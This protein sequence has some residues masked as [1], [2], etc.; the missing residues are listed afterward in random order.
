MQRISILILALCFGLLQSAWA[1]ETFLIGL[2]LKQDSL[3]LEGASVVLTSKADQSKQGSITSSR[4]R[5]RFKG[6]KPGAYTLSVDFVGYGQFSKD[7]ELTEGPN[8]AGRI[9]LGEKSYEL[10]KVVIKG[11]V[12]PSQQKG[13]TTEYNSDAFKTN[14]DATTENLL[15][16]MPGIT[17]QNGQVQAQGEQVRQVLVDGKPF[18]GT[19]PNAALKNLPAEVVQKIQVFDQQSEQA[20]STGFDDGE[21]TKTINIITKPETRNGTFGRLYGGGGLED[22]DKFRYNS[23]G[24]INVFDKN[25]RISILGQVNNIN[26]QNFASEDLAGV[27]SSGG[28]RRGFRGGGGGPPGRRGGSNVSDFLVNEQ[29]GITS[30]N[31]FGIN[32]TD[33]WGKKIEIAGS[34]FFNQ[35]DNVNE[36]VL[37][38][39]YINNGETGQIYEENDTSDSRN[40]NHRLNLR[41][42]F[43]LSDKTRIIFRPRVTVQ[44]NSGAS[45]SNAITSLS[46]Q[47]LNQSNTDFESDLT[48]VSSS[49]FLVF[50]HNFDKRGRSFSAS[51]RANYDDQ[52]GDNLLLSDLEYFSEPAT[53]ELVQQ[54]GTLD[55][56]GWNIR[57]DLRYS[58]PIGK[59]GMLQLFYRVNP[60]IEASDKQTLVPNNS[61]NDFTLIDT[62]LTNTFNS[63]YMTHEPGVG[64]FI[65]KSKLFVISR[66]G[67]QFANLQTERT[68]PSVQNTERDFS[69]LVPFALFRYRFSK[70][71]HLRVIYI[72]R[73]TAP[74]VT[75]LQDVIDN[76]NPLQL[77]SGNP[78]L[79]QSYAHR[80]IIRYNKT[81]TQ[82]NRTFIAFLNA[83]A[84][85]NH[86]G[87]QTIRPRA[88]TTIAGDFPL[89]AGSQYSLPVNLDGY[90]IGRAFISTGKL[91]EKLKVNVNV[92]AS[93]DYRRQPG[94]INNVLNFSNTTTLGV[95][96]VI[97]SNISEKVDFTLSSRTTA[98]QVINT[99]QASQNNNFLQQDSKLRMNLIFG[100]QIVFRSTL[101]HTLYSGLSDS[102]NQNFWLWNLGLA[103]KLGKKD[104]AEIQVSTFD[105]LRQNTSIQRTVTD[106]YIEDLESLVLQRYVLLTF[107]YNIRNFQ[108]GMDK[109][110][111]K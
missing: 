66:I 95:G 32:Y 64:L 43:K 68:F 40:V 103:K 16:K 49:N 23:G 79:D 47:N 73:T 111:D 101:S 18:F 104:Q 88:D 10:D 46:G 97:S 98:N 55:N 36:S 22:L 12:P 69:A 84:E 77:T 3:A 7:V 100:P 38:Q 50:R 61:A 63:Q 33:N 81:N 99:V 4:G 13:D 48:A 56:S 110:R 76:S 74:S 90:F 28:R 92:D 71:N 11:Q 62:S 78:L 42:E 31:A 93:I 9:I 70:S 89:L 67:Y 35:T 39:Q 37:R 21:T 57:G 27:A 1:Q 59:L 5:F 24:N 51:I 2:V 45:F 25:R 109:V 86:I 26:L 107:T 6:L 91:I 52:V 65:R 106:N 102:F 85:E 17:I 58:E 8:F 105:A 60:Q 87:T 108:N 82:K 80:F 19:D 53:S 94:L 41:M 96:L 72:G 30:T 34:Y 44:Q 54:K 14:P 15:E 29:G 20:Q 83:T 75:Q